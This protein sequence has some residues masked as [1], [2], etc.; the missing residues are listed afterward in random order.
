MC[1]FWLFGLNGSTVWASLL[2]RLASPRTGCPRAVSCEGHRPRWIRPRA[3]WRISLY[4]AR[5]PDRP[6]V[7]RFPATRSIKFDGERSPI[8]LRARK[9]GD[10]DGLAYRPGSG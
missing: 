6:V 3:T 7:L 1:V 5:A 9:T 8:P 2:A 10:V 4:T